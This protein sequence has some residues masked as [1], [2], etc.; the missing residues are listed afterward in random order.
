M[1]FRKLLA[2][3]AL[4]AGGVVAVGAA[5][6]PAVQAQG[7]TGTIEGV[8]KDKATGQPLPGATVVATSPA[9]KGQ[10]VAITDEHGR[11]A[12][13][14]LPPGTY[15]VTLYYADQTIERKGVIAKVDKITPLA[16]VLDTS[17]S[18]GEVIEIRETV[19][20]IDPTTTTQGVVI[21]RSYVKNIPV[22]GRTFGHALG[23]AAGS[24]GDGSGTS[25]SGS[26]S[27]E[28]RYLINGV[29]DV[30]RPMNTEAYDRIDENPF[31]PV[32]DQ[33][34]STFS[35]DVDTAS[36]ANVRRFLARGPAAAGRRGPDR[37]DD[38]L[39]PVRLPAARPATAPFAVTTEVG[40]ARGTPATS[41]SASGRE[42][43]RS[44]PTAS[45]RATWS[46]SSTC[47]ARW[48]RPTSCR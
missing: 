46:S 23:A 38:Q 36:Y 37:G 4:G 27:L 35:I 10:Q 31:Y 22:P 8:V 12:I 33:P 18:K 13:A 25:F 42:P 32:A 29:Q 16:M 19:P 30:D 20:H 48:S 15:L 43:R 34:L 7:T 44:P 9:S 11:Y 6:A 3:V 17:A 14:N 5:L 2:A 28:N 40:P 1:R 47:R 24:Q 26:T 41:W 39:L 21:S 45:R